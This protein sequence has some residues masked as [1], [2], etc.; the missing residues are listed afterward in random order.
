MNKASGP[1]QAGTCGKLALDAVR[2]A[3]Q[4]TTSA[5]SLQ[6]AAA[7]SLPKHLHS[8]GPHPTPLPAPPVL[9]VRLRP[10]HRLER[11]QVGRELGLH[12]VD[13]AHRRFS[14]VVHNLRQQGRVAEHRAAAVSTPLNDRGTSILAPPFLQLCCP[15][16]LCPCSTMLPAPTPLP[17]PTVFPH[18]QP[19]PLTLYTC[20]DRMM[21]FIRSCSS[22]NP[23]T[24][25]LQST[26]RGG[27]SSL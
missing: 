22:C 4:R 21:Q 15:P 12:I 9:H 1:P 20:S 26:A 7:G 14:A 18:S 16:N 10:L 2:A 24:C 13:Q 11:N 17:F 23:S 6:D 3:A 5:T 27:A 25:D 8:S 19:S